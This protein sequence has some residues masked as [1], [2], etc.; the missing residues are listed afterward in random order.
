MDHDRRLV[1]AAGLVGFAA[2][3][4]SAW[5]DL[6][7]Q[8]TPD[9]THLLSEKYLFLLDR[10]PAEL[11]LGHNL[12]VFAILLQIA[13]IWAVGQGLVPGSRGAARAYVLVAAF[14]MAV[15][16][17]FHATFAPIGLALHGAVAAGADPA[18]LA[19]IAGQAR[20]AQL[21]LGTVTLLAIAAASLL[22][23]A[24]VLRRRTAYPRW[25][26]GVTPLTLSI[27]LGIA[28]RLVPSLRL[29]LV[30]CGINCA[31]AVFFLFATI[32]LWRRAP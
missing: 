32:A 13:G 16:A 29:V 11:L 28:G 10:S 17:A 20:P 7:L 27:V 19:A 3:V 22:F 26:A 12:G 4:L 14:A 15:G 21:L 8:Y 18:K 2:A 23:S 9:A 1:R 5:A 25:M 6:T 30:P 31:G 24:I